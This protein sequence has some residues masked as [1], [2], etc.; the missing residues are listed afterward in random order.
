MLQ[1]TLKSGVIHNYPNGELDLEVVEQR[2]KQE[3]WIVNS[4]NNTEIYRT[5][6]IAHITIQKNN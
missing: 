6:E 3:F 2:L 4:D 5:S 1:I